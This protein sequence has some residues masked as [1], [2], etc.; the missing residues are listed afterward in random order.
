MYIVLFPRVI[1]PLKVYM[2]F[3]PPREHLGNARKKQISCIKYEFAIK[4]KKNV[5]EP[6]YTAEK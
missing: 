6:F 2:N 4:N 1:P 3:H 5:R